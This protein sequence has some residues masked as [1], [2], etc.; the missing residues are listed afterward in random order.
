[1]TGKAPTSRFAMH[2]DDIV[3][4]PSAQDLLRQELESAAMDD[5][6]EDE[7]EVPAGPGVK[8]FARAQALLRK[9]FVKTPKGVE[10]YGLPMGAH[11]P[12]TPMT[13][14]DLAMMSHV[15]KLTEEA[16][17]AKNVADKKKK[18]AAE[19]KVSEPVKKPAK[20]KVPFS[21]T[22]PVQTDLDTAMAEAQAH[23][24]E[25][26]L[27]K[28]DA[29][30][31]GDNPRG[32]TQ[33]EIDLLGAKVEAAWDVAEGIEPD[34]K[35]VKATLNLKPLAGKAP[36]KPSVSDDELDDLLAPAGHVA[37]QKQRLDEVEPYTRPRPDGWPDPVELEV[38][39]RDYKSR[40]NIEEV[41][42]TQAKGGLSDQAAAVRH[43]GGSG[44]SR[45]NELLRSDEHQ[46]SVF[47]EDSERHINNLDAAM[48]HWSTPTRMEGYRIID[49]SNDQPEIPVEQD[50]KVGDVIRDPGFASFSVAANNSFADMSFANGGRG[51]Y[52]HE[53]QESWAIVLDV[54]PGM[55]GVYM[56]S[57]GQ[58]QVE[59]E[60]EI[61][62]RR[63][64]NF[65]VVQID[66]DEKAVWLRIL[67]MDQ[68]PEVIPVGEMAEA[69]ADVR[70][71]SK[72]KK[73]SGKF[74]WR[75]DD[76]RK[77]RKDLLKVP[78]TRK[79]GR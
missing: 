64:L 16:T 39:D 37:K 44:Y 70:K 68:Q 66:P 52:E 35:V 36:A 72:L 29:E 6:P 11:I 63:D 30:F 8:V 71:L 40:V 7:D 61:V 43:Y 58:A 20:K 73:G 59:T 67:P 56:P 25:D 33:D 76:V 15:A 60:Y 12:G 45:M 32:I 3:R 31:H 4:L 79:N 54:P 53:K 28:L 47:R 46:N 41:F 24:Y 17:D 18:L 26:E 27:S 77:V 55:P 34:P 1:M 42:G 65:E 51:R 10:R 48:A 50:W 13:A 38:I 78:T 19:P 21:I 14:D 75:S 9:D 22:G 2:G 23:A 69:K 49:H 62:P 5:Q 57:T 74:A